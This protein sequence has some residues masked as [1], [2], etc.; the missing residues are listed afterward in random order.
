MSRPGP[1]WNPW[2][3]PEGSD[4]QGEIDML[5]LHVRFPDMLAPH[6]HL[7][8]F[9]RPGDKDKAAKALGQ[10]VAALKAGDPRAANRAVSQLPKAYSGIV[11]NP[12]LNFIK[13]GRRAGYKGNPDGQDIYPTQVDHG[14]D[15]PIGGGT[16][17]M[18]ALQN[19]LLI[20]QGKT[21]RRSNPKIARV[22]ARYL[23]RI[24][25]VT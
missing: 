21:P 12:V 16:D 13:D 24:A 10:L 20:E 22:A 2:P 5:S 18:K 1:H 4:L 17:V 3:Q 7:E 19:R 14:Y 15:Q 8:R 25:G 6:S 11:G 9:E 23:R